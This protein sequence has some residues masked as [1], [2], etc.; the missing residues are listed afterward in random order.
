[1]ECETNQADLTPNQ[2][3]FC[4][5]YVVDRNGVQ[6]YFRAFGRLTSKGSPRSYRAAQVEAS[7]LL[8]NPIIRK[9]I[10]AAR[11][12]H[13]RSCHVSARRVLRE[14][15]AIA[16][17]DPLDCFGT[18]DS[19]GLLRPLDLREVSPMARRTMGSI[20]ITSKSIEYRFHDKLNALEML[21]K[22]LGLFDKGNALQQL[23]ALIQNENE[24]H[25]CQ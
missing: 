4:D 23:I 15:V 14:L 12:E 19:T 6:A 3:R 18:D 20:K 8:S 5:E 1:M 10:D 7:R 25:F 13:S 22:H 21:A 11:T 24:K 9:E 16:F 17:A 2:Q